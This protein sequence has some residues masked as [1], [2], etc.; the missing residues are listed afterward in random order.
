MKKLMAICIVTL[1]C[2]H[3][4]AADDSSQVAE[5]MIAQ[6]IL[7]GTGKGYSGKDLEDFVA[8]CVKARQSSGADDPVIRAAMSG[9]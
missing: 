9:C 4:A 6:C 2:L 8:T 7:Q 3:F 1:G 5:S